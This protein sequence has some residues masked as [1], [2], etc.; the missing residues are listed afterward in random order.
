MDE[1]YR[2]CIKTAKND[3]FCEEL[4]IEND[5]EIVLINF[6]C[7]DYLFYGASASKAVQ[8]VSTWTLLELYQLTKTANFIATPMKKTFGS[9]LPAYWRYKLGFC[10]FFLTN[11]NE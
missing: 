4:L 11:K 8:K 5:F 7:Y 1:P 2:K 6:C 3:G 9:L 10:L